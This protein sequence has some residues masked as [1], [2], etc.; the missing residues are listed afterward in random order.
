MEVQQGLLLAVE[1]IDGAGKRTCVNFLRRGLDAR[2]IASTELS[3]PD[4]SSP[5]GKIIRKYLDSELDPGPAELF[6]TYFTDIYKDQAQLKELLA[7]GQVVIA[8][9]YFPSTVAF[10][11]AK[12]FDYQTALRILEAARIINADVGIFIE[13]APEIGMKRSAKRSPPDRHE[14]DLQLLRKVAVFYRRLVTEERLAKKWV[15]VNGNTTTRDLEI[16]MNSQ[17]DL[18]FGTRVLGKGD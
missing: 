2:G 3:Y 12:G 17:L 6:S 14:R 15:V 9:R 7:R 18:I 1:G 11:C 16:S 13:T 10:E 8:D 4:Y 5:W